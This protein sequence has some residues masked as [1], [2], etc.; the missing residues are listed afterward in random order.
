MF[1]GNSLQWHWQ[2]KSCFFFSPTCSQARQLSESL[3][4]PL[5]NVLPVK[6]YCEELDLDRD[7]NILLFMAVEK[8]LNYA[9]SFFENQ[10]SDD[11]ADQLDLYRSNDQIRPAL[12]EQ[13]TA[14]VI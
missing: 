10:V 5:N 3:G 12:S 6:N 2:L 7:T 1:C 8:M 11:R 14:E 13:R 9:D 4:I